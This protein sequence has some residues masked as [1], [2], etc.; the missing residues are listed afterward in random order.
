MQK[1]LPSLYRTGAVTIR[2]ECVFTNSVPI[3]PYR[4]AGRPE[5][6]YVMERLVD[7]AACETARDPAELRRRNAI[8]PDAMPYRAATGITLDS[9]DQKN[10]RI[11]AQSFDL[12]TD[13]TWIAAEPFQ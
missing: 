4:G 9:G 1:N 13:F 8:P 11:H 7:Q 10:I 12:N 2:T 6:N 5:A 3:G